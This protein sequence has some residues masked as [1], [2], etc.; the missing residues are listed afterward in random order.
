[1]INYSQEQTG[2]IELHKKRALMFLNDV[3]VDRKFE[4][5]DEIIH[6]DYENESYHNSMNREIERLDSEVLSEKGQEGHKTRMQMHLKSLKYDEIRIRKLMVNLDEFMVQADTT[7]SFIENGKF[8][9]FPTTGNVKQLIQVF[10]SFK[11]KDGLI[12]SNEFLQ[13]NVILIMA[14][15]SSIGQNNDK[16]QIMEYLAN[17][18]RMK[19]IPEYRSD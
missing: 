17:L 18:R 8:L 6:P 3:I 12:V 5:L 11:F 2:L 10:A 1:M 9:G 14:L 7:L 13:D 19:L 16:K 15:G 4:I